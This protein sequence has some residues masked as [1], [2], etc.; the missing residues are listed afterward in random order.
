MKNTKTTG[1]VFTTPFSSL[2]EPLKQT[3]LVNLKAMPMESIPAGANPFHHDASSMGTNLSRG[4]MMM[5]QGEFSDH[6]LTQPYLVNTVTGQRFL[7][8]FE[9][10][11]D[12]Y[13][14]AVWCGKLDI[15]HGEL[16][17]WSRSYQFAEFYTLLDHLRIKSMGKQGL[18]RG[19]KHSPVYVYVG[20]YFVRYDVVCDGEA[21][22]KWCKEN[23]LLIERDD[24]A[25]IAAKRYESAQLMVAATND[26]VGPV[27]IIDEDSIR[28]RLVFDEREH[29]AND[30][31]RAKHGLPMDKG[32]T[33]RV[34][35]DGE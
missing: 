28:K 16:Y 13:V 6:G 3:D 12:T 31:L 18:V 25:V 7:L 21:F 1:I 22:D 15:D 33:V 9:A 27:V 17:V 10:Q 14:D 11:E 30:V 2:I 26:Q 24:P 20:E 19:Y 5:H 23:D 35:P 29:T 4:W 32:V 8:N 34:I